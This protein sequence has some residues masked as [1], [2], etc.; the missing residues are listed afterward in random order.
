MEFIYHT[1]DDVLIKGNYWQK[2]K[3][4]HKDKDVPSH[5]CRCNTNGITWFVHINDDYILP[6]EEYKIYEHTSVA[7]SIITDSSDYIPIGLGQDVLFRTCPSNM[8]LNG[9]WYKGTI[10]TINADTYTVSFKF[11][12]LPQVIGI[13][14][15]EVPKRSTFPYV[16]N[17]VKKFLHTTTTEQS[18]IDYWYTHCHKQYLIDFHN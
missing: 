8:S 2:A 15:L 4:S 6:Y 9:I 10:K 12:S 11:E 14:V 17:L 16:D 7:K 3:Y 5:C 1:G 13:C 18:V